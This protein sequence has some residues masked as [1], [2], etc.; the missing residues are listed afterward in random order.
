MRWQLSLLSAPV[1]CRGISG[2]WIW[3]MFIWCVCSWKP[4]IHFPFPTQK[5]RF[6]ERKI[7]KFDVLIS[8][9]D[10]IIPTKIFSPNIEQ[11]QAN[12]KSKNHQIECERIDL[13]ISYTFLC[14]RR[15][16]RKPNVSEASQQ[17]GKNFLYPYE[18]NQIRF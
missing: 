6:S 2:G 13:Q 18:R 8:W 11:Y 7:Q 16:L 15:F 17:F 1:L 9:R 10:L 12:W 3:I 5:S 4:E 14:F